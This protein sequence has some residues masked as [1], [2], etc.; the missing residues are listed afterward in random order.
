MNEIMMDIKESQ[1]R[2]ETKLNI[3]LV[4]VLSLVTGIILNHFKII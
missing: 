2:R 3:L 1:N 4:A